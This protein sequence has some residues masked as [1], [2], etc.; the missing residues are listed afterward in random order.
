MKIS[1]DLPRG[2][3]GL[4]LL[5]TVLSGTLTLIIHSNPA[6]LEAL[7]FTAKKKATPWKTIDAEQVESGATIPSDTNVIV[8]LPSR[9][10]RIQRET[11]LGHHGKDTR[12]WGYCYPETDNPVEL[13]ATIGFP[14]KLFL[15]EAERAHRLTERLRLL[16]I[17]SIFRPPTR[18]EIERADDPEGIHGLIRHQ[19]EIFKGGQT[20][21]IMTEKPLSIG[22][23]I[24]HDELNAAEERMVQTDPRNGDTDR[25]GV[26]DGL[27]VHSLGTDPL[28][29]DTD[30]DGLIEGIEDENRNGKVDADETNPLV[31]DSDH[32][33]LCDGYCRQQAG[34]RLCSD[35][36]LTQCVTTS[37]TQ[38]QGEDK[39]L[40]GK[41]DP[42]ETDPRKWSTLNDG[43]S[44]LQHYY[45]CLLAKKTD[46]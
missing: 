24:D 27:E 29:R 44:D 45:R 14:G 20:C 21:F 41:M 11:L 3:L 35:I 18:D 42:G 34:L 9:M 39:N 2:T 7:V 28:R 15:S 32:D 40:N 1:I 8:R 26:T 25:D 31:L 10:G 5:V 19:V 16:P 30:A 13:Q 22:T 12:Y 46:C 43:I 36:V 33:G 37:Q 23:D 17:F 38:W 4:V 6:S